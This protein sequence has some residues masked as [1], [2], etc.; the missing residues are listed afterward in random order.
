MLPSKAFTSPP[1]MPV[2]IMRWIARTASGLARTFFATPSRPIID[3]DSVFARTRTAPSTENSLANKK[4]RRDV[5]L[6]LS[7]RLQGLELSGLMPQT[8]ARLKAFET[9]A[10]A[11][12]AVPSGKA[13]VVHDKSSA[14]CDAVSNWLPVPQ[15]GERRREG[16]KRPSPPFT[17]RCQPAECGADLCWAFAP[18]RR[19]GVPEPWAVGTVLLR[20]ALPELGHAPLHAQ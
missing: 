9:T 8:S 10:N 16:Q 11:R 1:P 2:K 15:G 18:L 13:G 5:S 20:P 6:N 3:S 7:T 17:S 19:C 4:R 12:L 14:L